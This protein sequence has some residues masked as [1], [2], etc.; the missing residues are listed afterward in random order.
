[1]A[2]RANLADV[3]RRYADIVDVDAAV[4]GLEGIAGA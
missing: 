2:H 1:L 4:R 3:G